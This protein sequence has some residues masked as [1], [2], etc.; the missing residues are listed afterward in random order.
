MAKTLISPLLILLVLQLLSFL[1]L[2]TQQH[3]LNKTA[4]RALSLFLITVLFFVFLS[5]PAVS[6]RLAYLLER[7]FTAPDAIS[8]GQLE[9]VTVLSGGYHPGSVPEMGHLGSSSYARVYQGVKTFKEAGAET[10]VVQGRWHGDDPELVAETMKAVAMEMGVPEEQILV[11]P[12]SS[13]TFQH[14]RELIMLDAIDSSDRIAVVTSAW[15][16]NRA[17]R[18]FDNF[19]S[20]VQPVPAEFYSYTRPPGLSGWLPQLSALQMSTKM[21]HELAGQLWYRVLN[22]REDRSLVDNKDTALQRINSL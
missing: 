7:P 6:V 19:F 15:H 10:L 5:L 1:L 17:R 20:Q 14:P 4:L 13:N 22:F 18:E 21:I 16:L 12:N 8:P 3:R 2:K 11:E 9:I